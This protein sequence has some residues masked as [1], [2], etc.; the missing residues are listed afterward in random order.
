MP[1]EQRRLLSSLNKLVRVERTFMSLRKFVSSWSRK[2][3]K[4]KLLWRR[5]RY[6]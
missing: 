6:T 1:N 4:F 5:L 2:K 3:L